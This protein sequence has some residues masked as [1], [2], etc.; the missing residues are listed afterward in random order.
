MSGITEKQ[1]KRLSVCDKKKYPFATAIGNDRDVFE[2]YYFK[3]KQDQLKADK[4]S[5]SSVGKNWTERERLSKKNKKFD[6]SK[7]SKL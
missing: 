5:G 1:F 3:S 6:F 7:W 4:E 2:T